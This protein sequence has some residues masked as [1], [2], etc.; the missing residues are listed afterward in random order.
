MKELNKYIID[1]R[2]ENNISQG[3]LA[4]HLGITQ[5]TLSNIETGKIPINT[6]VLDKLL[7]DGVVPISATDIAEKLK[8]RIDSMECEDQLFLFNVAKRIMR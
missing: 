5:K 4:E 3:V 2:K 6:K 8:N 1:F 7:E